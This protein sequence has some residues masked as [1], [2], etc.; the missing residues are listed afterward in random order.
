MEKL[1]LSL[2]VENPVLVYFLL[3]KQSRISFNQR[4]CQYLF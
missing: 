3:M 1:V 4:A 2:N